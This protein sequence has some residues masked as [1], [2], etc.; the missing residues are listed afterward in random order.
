ML[1]VYSLMLK[2]RKISSHVTPLTNI[3]TKNINIFLN[4]TFQ[5]QTAEERRKSLL[6]QHWAIPSKD[7]MSIDQGSE[8]IEWFNI[9]IL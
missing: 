7:R 2:Y 9:I 8:V 5:Q 3:I 6:D 1:F 4:I